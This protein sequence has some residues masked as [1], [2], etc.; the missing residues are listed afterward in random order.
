M[1]QKISIDIF[2]KHHEMLIKSLPD[3]VDA[4][5]ILSGKEEG[6][7]K[8]KTR[9][10]YIWLFGYDMIETIFVVTRKSLL[11]LASNKKCRKKNLIINSG[12]DGGNKIEITEIIRSTADLKVVD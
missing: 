7:N 12:D 1:D 2:L 8:P 6:S 5:F 9:A 10:L 4:F 11:Y 3:D